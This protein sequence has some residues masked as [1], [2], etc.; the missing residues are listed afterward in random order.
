MTKVETIMKIESA[1]S[2]I[3]ISALSLDPA[4]AP[5]FPKEELEAE[6]QKA[7]DGLA[8]ALELLQSCQSYLLNEWT[9]ENE[10]NKQ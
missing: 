6:R 7:K 5:R 10:E 2:A 8:A 9:K 1:K 3:R 4:K